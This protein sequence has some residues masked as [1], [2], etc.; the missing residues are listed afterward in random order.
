MKRLL[1]FALAT[2]LAMQ[3]AIPA[4]AAEQTNPTP[5]SIPQTSS[6]STNPSVDSE[7]EVV[8]TLNSPVTPEPE[9]VN[10]LSSVA[11]PGALS[12][13]A[14]YAMNVPNGKVGIEITGV[15]PRNFDKEGV[16]PYLIVT[17]RVVDKRSS[18]TPFSIAHYNNNSLFATTPITMT[19]AEDE[20]SVLYY[21]GQAGDNV[22]KFQIEELQDSQIAQKTTTWTWDGNQF[23]DIKI[24]DAGIEVNLDET[25][26]G[27]NR[28]TLVI[29][30]CIISSPVT[31]KDLMTAT[32]YCDDVVIWQTTTNVNRSESVNI[33][34]HVTLEATP[35]SAGPH[36]WKIE[37]NTGNK[38]FE[39]DYTNNSKVI[40]KNWETVWYGEV[41]KTQADTLFYTGT[42]TTA[43][44]MFQNKSSDN[45]NAMPVGIFLDDKLWKKVTV[46]IPFDDAIVVSL[47][48]PPPNGTSGIVR[49]EIDPDRE[50]MTQESDLRSK[51][52]TV[53]RPDDGNIKV[54]L[55]YDG[56]LEAGKQTTFHLTLTNTSK[57]FSVSGKYGLRLADADETSLGNIIPETA[58]TLKPGETKTFDQNVTISNRGGITLV[59]L[60]V[61]ANDYDTTDNK[62]SVSFVN[63]DEDPYPSFEITWPDAPPGS[64]YAGAKYTTGFELSYTARGSAPRVFN[65][66]KVTMYLDGKAVHS[67]TATIRT[68]TQRF[69]ATI[70][71]VDMTVGNHSFYWVIDTGVK[72]PVS[73]GNT[74]VSGDFKLPNGNIGAQSD[75]K[76]FVVLENQDLAILSASLDKIDGRYGY[77]DTIQVEVRVHNPSR[78]TM[79]SL[80]LDVIGV[81]I[82]NEEYTKTISLPPNA[83]GQFVYRVPAAAVQ[84]CDM[85]QVVINADGRYPDSTTDNNV[86]QQRIYVSA[87]TND[88]LIKDVQVINGVI[89]GG[90]PGEFIVTVRNESQQPVSGKLIAS[91]D[92]TEIYNI[93]VSYNASVQ[94]EH[95]F[96][97]FFYRGEGNKTIV[98]QVVPETDFVDSNPSN[99]TRTT[100]IQLISDNNV[101][102]SKPL[103]LKGDRS[104]VIEDEDAEFEAQIT[105]SSLSTTYKVRI[106]FEQDGQKLQE[107]YAD[108][109]PRAVR[110]MS[111]K[112]W[113]GQ[114]QGGLT[115]AD[116]RPLPAGP[117]HR[118]GPSS[119]VTS[120]IEILSG[121]DMNPA[122]NLS[123]LE[124][125]C[126]PYTNTYIKEKSV[127]MTDGVAQAVAS[128][129]SAYPGQPMAQV[130]DVNITFSSESCILYY[131]TAVVKMYCKDDPSIKWIP[132][133][134]TI[135]WGQKAWEQFFSGTQYFDSL[136]FAYDGTPGTR[137]ITVELIPGIPYMGQGYPDPEYYSGRQDTYLADNV[138][139]F[140]VNFP[141][142]QPKV[143]YTTG[144]A[145][146]NRYIKGTSLD[147]DIAWYSSQNVSVAPEL[148]APREILV[149]GVSVWSST[150]TFTHV[151]DYV[152]MSIPYDT[153]VEKGVDLNVEELVV[154]AKI[155]GGKNGPHKYAEA[156]TYNSDPYYDNEKELSVAVLDQSAVE[157]YWDLAVTNVKTDKTIYNPGDTVKITAVVADNSTAPLPGPM[158][159]NVK[160]SVGTSQFTK[161]IT[162]PGQGNF[163]TMEVPVTMTLPAKPSSV[164]AI[165]AEINPE[166]ETVLK[167]KTYDNNTG[168]T[169]ITVAVPE[170]KVDYAVTVD[171]AQTS[172]NVGESPTITFD[173]TATSTADP[174]QIIT[175]ANLLVDGKR[176]ANPVITWDS[177]Y[178]NQLKYTLP[179]SYTALS[180][181][182]TVQLDVN[183]SRVTDESDYTNNS[184]IATVIVKPKV[185]QNELLV[186]YLK[187]DKTSYGDGEQIKLDAAFSNLSDANRAGIKTEVMIWNA[188]TSQ[189][190][191]LLTPDTTTIASYHTVTYSF[192]FRP[193]AQYISTDKTLKVKAVINSDNKYADTDPGNNEVILTVAVVTALDAEAVSIA[194]SRAEID[195]GATETITFTYRNNSSVVPVVNAVLTIKD[196]DIELAKQTVSLDPKESRTGTLNYRPAKTG[197]HNLTLTITAEGD[198]NPSNNSTSGKLI[199]NSLAPSPENFIAES[200]T[201]TNVDTGDVGVIPVGGRFEIKALI[202]FENV[203][204][205][206]SLSYRIL[207]K[208]TTTGRIEEIYKSVITQGNGMAAGSGTA[209]ITLRADFGWDWAADNAE[210]ILQVDSD[211]LVEESN[212]ADNETTTPLKVDTSFNLFWDSW[213]N[214]QPQYVFG[215]P[216]QFDIKSL[217]T[218]MIGEEIPTSVEL[219]LDG[220][221]KERYDFA[222][223]T[224]VEA[225]LS[226]TVLR[227][228]AGDHVL[229]VRINENRTVRETTYVDNI[230]TINF[231][232]I[233]GDFNW[234]VSEF[235]APKNLSH[236][237]QPDIDG[238][239]VLDMDGDISYRVDIG[240]VGYVEGGE[241]I[242]VR[243]TAWNEYTDETMAWVQ[244][245]P[246]DASG[247]PSS[248]YH[249]D[250]IWMNDTP[251]RYGKNIFTLEINPDLTADEY[252]ELLD[253]NTTLPP[254]Q[255]IPLS[256]VKIGRQYEET[257][258][259][260]NKTT[261]KWIMPEEPDFKVEFYNGSADYAL[262]DEYI[263]GQTVRGVATLTMSGINPANVRK[264]TLIWVAVDGHE[265]AIMNQDF[266]IIGEDPETGEE[267]VS[268]GLYK[269]F[270]TRDA[271][272]GEHTIQVFINADRRYD[273]INWDNN[274]VEHTFTVKPDP[275]LQDFAAQKVKYVGSGY[276]GDPLEFEVTLA[277][278]LIKK[279]E[280]PIQYAIGYP[281]EDGAG[282]Y[283]AHIGETEFTGEDSYTFTFTVPHSSSYVK[284][285]TNEYTLILNPALF[286]ASDRFYVAGNET[287]KANNKIS[288]VFTLKD[289]PINLTADYIT[290]D[291]D[292]VS[293]E[294]VTINYSFS[295][296]AK[297]TTVRDITWTLYAGETVIDTGTD[298][299]GG[300]DT[301]EDSVDWNLPKMTG[302]LEF[303]LVI[304]EG[305]T[306][307]ETTYDDNEVSVTKTILPAQRDLTVYNAHIKE[308]DESTEV[309]VGD[310][311]TL[312]F[313]ALNQSLDLQN[314]KDVADVQYNIYAGDMLI[315]SGQIDSLILDKAEVITTELFVPGNIL[316]GDVA[317]EIIINPDTQENTG[318]MDEIDMTNNS[319]GTTLVISPPNNLVIPNVELP[320]DILQEGDD[321]DLTV[322]IKNEN[323]V[324]PQNPD[325]IVTI[326]GTEVI[327]VPAGEI[328]ANGEIQV[329]IQIPGDGISLGQHD[330]VVIVNPDRTITEDD[331]EDNDFTKPILVQQSKDYSA[332]FISVTPEGALP[333][334][335]EVT[336][337][338]EFA[339]NGKLQ[340]NPPAFFIVGEDVEWSE[341]LSLNPGQKVQKTFTLNSGDEVIVRQLEVGINKDNMST[342]ETDFTNNTDFWSISTRDHNVEGT[343]DDI[344]LD[345]DEPV[346]IEV[347]VSS[348]TTGS[349]I[350]ANESSSIVA[351]VTWDGGSLTGDQ[352]TMDVDIPI[353]P[354]ETIEITVTI[355]TDD[356][357]M[358]ED[359]TIIY[360]RPTDDVDANVVVQDS[361]GSRYEGERTNN[362]FEIKLPS[363]ISSGT[364]ILA[365]TADNANITEVGGDSML[366]PSYTIPSIAD[367]FSKGEINI[368]FTVTSGSGLVSENYTAHITVDN[369]GPT[370]VIVNASE[371]DGAMYSQ[372]G[373]YLDDMFT[374]YGN[375]FTTVEAARLADKQRGIVI[376]VA[377][378]DEDTNQLMY[379]DVTFDGTRYPIYWLDY[380]GE[381]ITASRE[382]IFG[383][384]YIPSTE[385]T[386]SKEGIQ[387]YATAY[388]TFNNS[389]SS[390][391]SKSNSNVVEVGLDVIGPTY[392]ISGTAESSKLWISKIKDNIIGTEAI[393]VRHRRDGTNT[394][395]PTYKFDNID[396][397]K[398]IEVDLGAYAGLRIFEVW[399]EDKLKNTTS[400]T[401][402]QLD[403]GDD[404]RAIDV[405]G[406]Y[407]TNS[408]KAT[409]VFINVRYRGSEKVDLGG[410][411][412][413]K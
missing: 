367:V 22:F 403:L 410:F 25:S 172:V 62:A 333:Y 151:R 12:T 133:S 117:L 154:T 180:G 289:E 200:I 411:D 78:V 346:E 125:E 77:D 132:D 298:W 196:G 203:S 232:V 24:L 237:G 47:E 206:Q 406:A 301:V 344:P 57:Y 81:G 247:Y 204:A 296:K 158:V 35:I 342:E 56:T 46:D 159:L 257:T 209:T 89:T 310:R 55:T 337:V 146:R 124:V 309:R 183:P 269:P 409:S 85:L 113:Y 75:T 382:E 163:N 238:Y 319:T 260:D 226:F 190:D 225:T 300:T 388:D 378:K 66:A 356:G 18:R 86:W 291:G 100:A 130:H 391:I 169:S 54:G 361:S 400:K 326:D 303:R 369:N 304:N 79:S 111:V 323:P 192:T 170:L 91:I 256:A 290:V 138:F 181:T 235:S 6:V 88:L 401:E 194:P 233:K 76:K 366:V 83:V 215:E 70:D 397:S 358:E 60:Y 219:Y 65:N 201:L 98:W 376:Q 264:D 412:F 119:T 96:H 29:F 281:S 351:E 387:L 404:G 141:N 375:G 186:S 224:G 168:S 36:D 386:E 207:L 302:P 240:K 50:F 359:Y 330:I 329:S 40:T 153:L 340:G 182:V 347:D 9:V 126:R 3:M 270:S 383:Y 396:E 272:L 82:P 339:N 5:E 299:L 266:Y 328:P 128:G 320:S 335:T 17:Y 156:L 244:Y 357:Y 155:N 45:W 177:Q 63:G 275:N 373:R 292:T 324:D 143:N 123:S 287:N 42:E 160:F 178:K 249:P 286:F 362:H 166:R 121:V 230:S 381:R 248:V 294:E 94:Q 282:M 395:T 305:R 385:F 162:I 331:Y 350:R 61:S 213:K 135:P 265:K 371:I 51:S 129:L 327:R 214:I 107:M 13:T 84:H 185:P 279:L 258:Y 14:T 184:A 325:I 218:G 402:F 139:E 137:T 407:A 26:Q 284:N 283:L 30:D 372:K 368:A 193:T 250:G 360:T 122:D 68:G 398:V 198:F 277:D 336:V 365:A 295:N 93:P 108:L 33:G 20:F 273:D 223:F 278:L 241:G 103:T 313:T 197:I 221:L 393:Y 72:Y 188:A 67:Q 268:S 384:A 44:V 405:E 115:T 297:Y 349:V 210:L 37:V 144:M 99:N 380:N 174:E 110:K 31:Y 147:F 280:G 187:S 246:S 69:T 118:W 161:G 345:A 261:M 10:A 322:T 23:A 271:G 53:N 355:K 392:D 348:P 343:V 32:L 315:G 2:L 74:I 11:A 354:G 15:S 90:A 234:Y 314:P 285:G 171:P 267:T 211:N 341:N 199:V 236:P 312:Y 243:M 64:V 220:V 175:T 101:Y 338:V 262:Q 306:I 334:D 39:T 4:F 317:L 229:E 379:A 48:V 157:Q 413:L 71:T 27:W 242:V 191:P 34:S 390:F 288:C 80:K 321:I 92:G 152:S 307:K 253:R 8:T 370:I 59:S 352:N 259:A 276:Y 145:L 165:S 149:N 254:E 353:N 239:T 363:N 43:G 136:L 205:T 179:S 202:G 21:N 389:T 212:E 114:D 228:A 263:F 251:Y 217:S 120:R 131:P 134:I 293:T 87:P 109:P 374:S 49:Y 394:W 140:K 189:W 38:L 164:Y 150:E 231:T 308:M 102:W 255:Q 377:A 142:M 311:V 28:K 332:K 105:N 41:V 97:N 167:E 227:P 73:H 222:A 58:I 19:S 116:G 52:I 245:L 173:L 195:L 16:Q 399:G 148:D 274:I 216:V 127:A 318:F 7:P 252:Q 408:R 112:V 208:N 176:V 316:Y 364:I 106:T 104:Y 95:I 1:S